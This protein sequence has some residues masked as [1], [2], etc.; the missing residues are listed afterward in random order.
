MKLIEAIQIV[1]ASAQSTKNSIDVRLLCGFTPLHLN[2]FA[3]AHLYNR[4]SRHVTIHAGQFEDLEESLAQLASESVSDVAVIIEWSDLDARLGYR[5]THGWRPAALTDIVKTV[6]ATLQRIARLIINFARSSNCVV[7]A[8]TLPLPPLFT[9]SG[10][11]EDPAALEMNQALNVF[12]LELSRTDSVHIVGRQYIDYHSPLRDRYDLA[13]DIR[14]GFPYKLSHAS[15]V[16]S[17]IADLLRPVPRKKGIIT[18]LDNTLWHGVLGED[19]ID[20]VSWD[21]D[22]NQHKHALYQEMLAGLSE[23]GVFVGIAS[24][25]DPELV[26]EALKKLD[27]VIP[28]DRFYPVEANWGNKSESATHILKKWNISADSIVFIDDSAMEREE[29]LKAHPGIKCLAFPINGENKF[30]AFLETLRGLFGKSHVTQEDAIRIDSIKTQNTFISH[31]ATDRADD[32]LSN[33]NAKLVFSKT[34][35]NKRT[36]ELINKTNQFNINGHRFT[37]AQWLGIIEDRNKFIFT[38]SYQDKFG[39]LGQIAVIC[40]S[41]IGEET[42]I[43]TWVMSCRAF[44]RRIEYQTINQLLKMTGRETIILDFVATQ[45]N[46]YVAKFID[47]IGGRMLNDRVIID[48]QTFKD[49]SPALFHEVEYK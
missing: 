29:V 5:S 19:G 28:A 13:S 24:K 3:A 47:Q 48:G 7:V 11:H 4:T 25:N 37:D 21:L 43:D 22:S 16:A 44:S 49:S 45:R 17:A 8:P 18:D 31:E 30:L 1:Q 32:F 14:S 35:F 33:T 27:L 20:G 40:G 23:L 15:L 2:T 39:P 36:L 10:E 34:A 6:C 12:C 41:I 9:N 46:K 42:V 38:V 26:H